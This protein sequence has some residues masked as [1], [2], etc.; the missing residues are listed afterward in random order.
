MTKGTLMTKPKSL[1]L[2]IFDAL[3]YLLLAGLS[4]SAAFGLRFDFALSPTVRPLLWRGLLVASL[5][6]VP[7]FCAGRFRR[8]L[9]ICAQVADLFRVLAWNILASSLFAAAAWWSIGRAFPRSVYLID[10]CVCFLAI[11]VVCFWIA[12]PPQ[13]RRRAHAGTKSILIYGAGAAGVALLQEIRRNQSLDYEVAGFLDDDRAKQGVKI[14]GVRVWGPGREAASIVERLNRARARIRV[15]EIVIA[16]PSATAAERSRALAYCRATRLPCKTMPATADLLEREAL[17]RQIQHVP[18]TDL[19]GRPLVQLDQE[20]I[21]RSIEGRCVLVTGAGG[22][23]GSELC[24]QI[25]QMRPSR[26]IALDQAESDLFRVQCELRDRHPRLDLV[27]ALGDIRNPRRLADVFDRNP[28]ESVFHAAAYKHVPMMEAH[29]RQAVENNILGT[30]N[31]VNAVWQR[32]VSRFLMIS[33]DKAV[34][35]TSVMGATKRACELIVAAAPRIPGET[36]CVS[37]RFGNVLGSNGSVVP[38]FQSQIAGGGPVRVTH[39]DIQRY[40]M[41]TSEAV[42]LVLQASSMGTD[43]EIFVLDMGDP[44]RIVDLAINMIRLAG[45]E[46]YRDIDIEFTGLRP[47]EKL[48][49][50]INCPDELTLRT[51]HDKIR[52]F[53]QAPPE[54]TTIAAWLDR[55]RSL[56]GKRSEE[57]IIDHLRELVPEYQSGEE[58]VPAGA[59][60]ASR[61]AIG[62]SAY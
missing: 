42:S 35:P 14:I 24:R 61:P 4:L 16:I 11:V 58:A 25:A 31:L 45:L 43:S 5:V 44:V 3:S 23:I 17:V 28:I 26:L 38:I 8:N 1:A 30:W 46:P 56:L 33:S 20:P 32:R 7:V 37:V 21:A 19:L 9:R 39:P 49:E 59:F 40:F 12:L 51:C 10:F 54:W 29:V 50:E 13:G 6:K 52:I 53:H 60:P 47:G 18:M 15:E 2:P 55:L 62:T 34:N 27:A 41:T 48:F 57:A 36:T 22:S